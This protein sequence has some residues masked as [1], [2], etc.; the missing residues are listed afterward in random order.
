MRRIAARAA[1]GAAT[2]PG[3]C[4]HHH[5][6]GTGHGGEKLAGLAQGVF[7]APVDYA[8]AVRRVLRALRPSVV[9]I[10]ETE[11]WPNLIREAKRTG[12]GVTIVNGRIS[13]RALPRYLRFRWFFQAALG[14]VDSVLAQSDE[15]RERFVAVGS[16]PECV[17]VG[18][19][20]KYD[21]IPRA[22]EAGSPVAAWIEG[23]RP[24]KVWI[25]ASTMPP[26]GPDDVDE[27]DVVIAA[28]RQAAKA[29]P[30]LALILAPRKPERFDAAA[31]KLEAAGV[32]FTRRSALGLADKRDG[33]AGAR[34]LLL[35]TIGELSGLFSLADVVF[36]GGTLA[37]RG[38]HNILEPALFG[39]PVIAGPHMENFQAIA[40]EFRA[41]G[42]YVEI[43][44]AEELA[45]EISRLLNDSGCI[46]V[47][48]KACAEARRGAAARAVSEI[49]ELHARRI[50]RYRPA[51]PWQAMASALARAWEWAAG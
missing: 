23:V 34:V 27:D 15:M 22:A 35:D 48:A 39:K 44:A 46:G 18:G 42:A 31:R 47:R 2:N 14:Q 13:N 7:Y 11:I 30:E 36:M 32:P 38:G 6:G 25:A 40:G 4:F 9:V 24:A 21:F 49:R 26:A 41:A 17:R 1:R 5:V 10:A 43:G 50:P 29:H 8:F 45:G 51:Q 12:A 37:R 3:L 19:N 16:M 33:K 28:Y 20:L